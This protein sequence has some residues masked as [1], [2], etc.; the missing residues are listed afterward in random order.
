MAKDYK[1]SG[2]KPAASGKRSGGSSGGGSVFAGL[3]IG[4]CLGVAIA[5]AAAL[6]LNKT[7]NPF[8]SK[9]P[10]NPAPQPAAPSTARPPEVMAPSGGSKQAPVEAVPPAPHGKPAANAPAQA[11]PQQGDRFDFYRMLPELGGEPKAG[12]TA[13]PADVTPP[14]T[15]QPAKGSYLQ[16][17][18]FQT[19]KDADN[20]KAKLAL[21]GMEA[22]IQTSEVTGKGLLHRVR[23]GPL[24]SADDI[25]RVRAQ[26]KVNGIDSA[27]VKQ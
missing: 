27:L 21:L 4:L 23:V 17:G 2:R 20:L 11:Q 8:G 22:T 9:A 24:A 12:T 6:Y 7:P 15:V 3:I 13:K 10:A 14:T 18:A 26:L 16:V 1:N 25:D 5:V 19:E